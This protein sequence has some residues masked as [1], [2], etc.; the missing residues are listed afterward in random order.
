MRDGRRAFH[1]PTPRLSARTAPAEADRVPLWARHLTPIATPAAARLEL[2]IGETAAWRRIMKIARLSLGILLI[3]PAGFAAGQS[4]TPP[5]QQQDT[6]SSS[7]SSLAEAAKR[8]REAKKDD[9]KPAR[10]WDNDTVPKAGAQISVVGEAPAGAD[11]DNSAASAAADS[12]ANGATA[13]KSPAKSG[14][15]DK[16][17]LK[18][19]IADAKEKLSTI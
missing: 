15:E 7:T 5:P 13:A 8:A 17:A 18:S 6:Q 14:G 3:L 2:R 16:S 11:A 10:V 9:Q 12:S 4:Q 1:L 19:Q